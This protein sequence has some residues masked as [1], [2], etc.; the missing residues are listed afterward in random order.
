[1]MEYSNTYLI[2]PQE[3]GPAILIDPGH[4][5]IDLI[6]RIERNNFT[7]AHVLITHRHASH[8]QGLGTLMKIYHP[9]VHAGSPTLFEVPVVAIEDNEQIVVGEIVIKALQV[10]GH[11]I[12]SFVFHIGNALFTGDVLY[13][14]TIGS[15]TGVVERALLLKGIKRNILSLDERTVIFPGHGTISTIKIEKMFNHDLIEAMAIDDLQQLS[16]PSILT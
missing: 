6:E 13:A 3:G 12:D 7:V 1:M 9:I 4:I 16:H 2:G 11:T 14:G 15:T 8:H 5:D 10:P